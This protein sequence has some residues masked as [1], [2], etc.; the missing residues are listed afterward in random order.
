MDD[1]VP[2]S[3]AEPASAAYSRR[4][5]NHITTSEASTPSAI[6]STSTSSM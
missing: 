5:E 4:R 1:G 2:S 6:W 3:F